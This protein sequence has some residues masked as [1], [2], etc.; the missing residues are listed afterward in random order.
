MDGLNITEHVEA[1]QE[2]IQTTP[3]ERFECDDG[4]N[5]AKKRSARDIHGWKVN[6]PRQC[7]YA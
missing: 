3:N 1:A 7:S 4:A 2:E 6:N 5:T